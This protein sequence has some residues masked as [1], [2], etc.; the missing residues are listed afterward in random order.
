[1]TGITACSTRGQEASLTLTASQ[2][3]TASATKTGDIKHK[4]G[5]PVAVSALTQ[6][7][8]KSHS[9]T[10]ITFT[11]RVGMAIK[12]EQVYRKDP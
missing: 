5:K 10:A 7:L 9:Q 3:C 4:N 12:A 6:V 8:R 1:M 2:A 11:I